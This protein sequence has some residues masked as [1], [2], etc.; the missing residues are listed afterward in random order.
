VSVVK[1][2]PVGSKA[3]WLQ[4]GISV[5]LT[6]IA[7]FIGEDVSLLDFHKGAE[8]GTGLVNAMDVW[9]ARYRLLVWSELAVATGISITFN[10]GLDKTVSNIK[11]ASRMLNPRHPDRPQTAMAALLGLAF[12]LSWWFTFQ[13]PSSWMNEATCVDLAHELS[14]AVWS[15]VTSIAVAFFGCNARA[16]LLTSSA[17]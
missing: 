17:K 2:F 10:D 4:A 3:A 11:A 15:L 1:F 16:A 14:S 5:V 12:I 6:A 9:N 13:Q 7:L 8:D